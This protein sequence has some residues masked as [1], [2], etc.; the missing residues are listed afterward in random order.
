MPMEFK[1][2]TKEV[3]KGSDSVSQSLQKM[4]KAAEKADVVQRKLSKTQSNAIKISGK[5]QKALDSLKVSMGTLRAVSMGTA[6]QIRDI[7]KASTIGGIGNAVAELT[8][9]Q[10]T[11]AGLAK[12]A[13]RVKVQVDTEV[14]NKEEIKKAD[15]AVRQLGESTNDV[16]E[17]F[18][19]LDKE[20]GFIGKRFKEGAEE[21]KDFADGIGLS[22]GKMIAG[23]LA[24]IYLAN[25]FDDLLTKFETARISL[26]KYR[27]ATISAGKTTIGFSKEGLEKLRRN[28]FLT[29]EQAT[30]Y[31]KVVREGTNILGMTPAKIEAVSKALQETFGGDPTER[32]REYVDLLKEIPT[33][34]TDLKITASLDDQSA[35]I[36]A[37]AQKGKM[38]TVMDLQQAG[39]MGPGKPFAVEADQTKLINQQQKVMAISERINDTM[40]R[41]YPTWGSKFTLIADYTNK[42]FKA[43]ASGAI[44]LG[45]LKFLLSKHDA[46][47]TAQI[48]RID[49]KMDRLIA[50]VQTGGATGGMPVFG[51]RGGGVGGLRLA[52]AGTPLGKAGKLHLAQPVVPA[53]HVAL[54]PGIPTEAALKG[55][56][57]T[58][59]AGAKLTGMFAK[60]S[61]VGSIA[62]LGFIAAGLA[63]DYLADSF[64]EAGDTTAAGISKISGGLLDVAGWVATGATIG[65]AFGGIGAPIGAAIG[66]LVGLTMN[67]ESIG[68][69]VRKFGGIWESVGYG[70]TEGGKFLK[71]FAKTTWEG[72]K[73]L[74]YWTS[75]IGPAVAAVKWFT[76]ITKDPKR[77][78]EEKLALKQIEKMNKQVKRLIDFS[79]RFEKGQ[80]EYIEGQMESGLALQKQMAMLEDEFKSGRFAIHNFIAE[81]ASA[82]MEAFVEAGGSVEGFASAVKAS[83]KAVSDRFRAHN[84]AIERSRKAIMD[85]SKLQ[86]DQRAHALADLSKKE[87]EAV[88]QFVKGVSEAAKALLNT[89]KIIEA[90]LKYQMSKVTLDLGVDI[91]GLGMGDFIK[92]TRKGLDELNTQLN[93]FF[94]ARFEQEKKLADMR[95]QL[96]EKQKKYITDMSEEQKRVYVKAGILEVTKDGL[97]VQKDAVVKYNE[98]LQ[99]S[100]ETTRGQIDDITK[101]MPKAGFEAAATS[102]Y[103]VGQQT[104]KLKTNLENLKK[105]EIDAADNAEKLTKIKERRK[106][107]EESLKEAKEQE[108]KW[109][110]AMKDLVD[111][112]REG[113]EDEAKK[114]GKAPQKISA[115]AVKGIMDEIGKGMATGKPFEL[116][117]IRENLKSVE[118]ANALLAAIEK[119]MGGTLDKFRKI[120]RLTEDLTKQV[121]ESGKIQPIIDAYDGEIAALKVKADTNETIANKVREVAVVIG[122]VTDMMRVE[123][124][125]SLERQV[126]ELQKAQDIASMLGDPTEAMTK[127]FMKQA[128]LLDQQLNV[129]DKQLE[130]A[131]ENNTRYEKIYEESLETLKFYE[132]RAKLGIKGADEELK[133]AQD[134]VAKAKV[135]VAATRNS[136][137]SVNKQRS[138]LL[139]TIPLIGE[140]MAK[141]IENLKKSLAGQEVSA[142][143][144]LSDALFDMAEFSKDFAAYAEEATQMAIG[145]AKE[146]AAMERKA[147]MAELA[148][149][150]SY[151]QTRIDQAKKAGK[152][153]AEIEGIRVTGE[154]AIQAKKR[155]MLAKVEVDEKKRVVESAK[156]EAEIKNSLI[157]AAQS[158]LEAEMEVASLRGGHLSVMVKY[159][160]EILAME[161][162]RVENIRKA[163]KEALDTQGNTLEVQKMGYQLRLAEANLQKK[164]LGYQRDIIE[165]M[166]GAALGEVRTAVGARRQRLTDIGLMGME[167]TRMKTAAGAYAA[168]G[169]GGVKPY[170]QRLAEY[171]TG[172]GGTRGGAGRLAP[173]EAMARG[174]ADSGVADNTAIT[175]KATSSMDS[176]SRSEHSLSVVDNLS[177]ELQEKANK[178]Q[179]KQGKIQKQQF[180]T[181]KQ[182]HA[183]QKKI[184][185]KEL[186]AAARL[187]GGKFGGGPHLGGG[188]FDIGAPHLGGGKFDIGA[189]HLGSGKFDITASH[190]GGGKFDVGAKTLGKGAGAGASE[191]K[192]TDKMAK[193]T[194]AAVSDAVEDTPV[195]TGTQT[196]A[197]ATASRTV[198]GAGLAAKP[199]FAGMAVAGGGAGGPAGAGGGTAA[200]PMITVGGEV[201]VRFDNKMFRDAV[202]NIVAQ[203]INT[204]E[205]MKNLQKTFVPYK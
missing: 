143:I 95:D 184:M 2:L 117:V 25:K 161:A 136:I 54:P 102:L 46:K 180:K 40:L 112:A 134:N 87:A 166:L 189:K 59:G 199:E 8:E 187:G 147:I 45:G 88:T 179:N 110:D 71:Q 76:E 115:D 7:T 139:N 125:R 128:E 63:A 200:A 94:S 24:A 90:G 86:G 153:L 142:R 51:G 74:L 33:L 79:K 170:W 135:A 39:V 93:G 120:G 113:M 118:G 55:T 99:K 57:K 165:K 106:G 196:R 188:K 171:Q 77:K 15:E 75:G 193:K 92:E 127:V 30:E 97:K 69:E 168:A 56:T 144:D 73:S 60:V 68:D 119:Q 177:A 13:K 158:A 151:L 148:N 20:L 123:E 137:E 108:D 204:P 96:A 124:V 31:F 14:K 91:G 181:Q 149:E 11:L 5:F 192:F 23:G 83:T 34:D 140:S 182:Q 114:A 122:K 205:I 157:D 183:D 101:E 43:V 98:D 36:F 6:K 82:K 50:A 172:M 37:L 185:K 131:K 141:G 156:K 47:R 155:T 10:K 130:L 159:Q 1:N 67:L 72:A 129:N 53:R 65:A 84:Q 81:V 191:E 198:M 176:Q 64:D 190:L 173:E 27:I 133:V 48:A 61:K 163:Y 146:R 162:D 175:A 80:R 58:I 100:I 132:K 4:M 62:S 201:T 19:R 22:G 49:L 160:K 21:A 194:G 169:P 32:L 111:K 145:A 109:R 138:D 12:T 203:N 105:E 121:T 178:E 126:T 202:V 35:A 3:T 41:F 44:A 186:S 38:E 17:D 197:I 103:L 174:L 26:A 85:D 167:R 164:S 78:K 28:L 107:V 150:E 66:A 70:L 9:L 18:N 29:R 104:D 89:P 116:D 195:L 52:P 42:V 16:Q 154:A 152:T